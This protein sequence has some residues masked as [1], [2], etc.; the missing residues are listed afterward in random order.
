MRCGGTF[1]PCV[2]DFHHRDPSTKAFGLSVGE[3]A[4]RSTTDVMA[5]IAKCDLL[6]ANCHRIVEHEEQPARDS[7]RD[8]E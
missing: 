1:P 3:C 7:S 8:K 6:C 4:S 2:M 5:E